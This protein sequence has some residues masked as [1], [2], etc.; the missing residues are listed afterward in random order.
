MTND[1]D[2]GGGGGG[3]GARQGLFVRE[4]AS[5]HESE[6]ERERVLSYEFRQRLPHGRATSV[7][8]W[9]PASSTHFSPLRQS[10]GRRAAGSNFAVA[11][12][13]VVIVGEE[14]QPT[15]KMTLMSIVTKWHG[16]REDGWGAFHTKVFPTCA[17]ACEKY[18]L[19]A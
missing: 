10:Q 3:A 5:R 7:H 14:Q 8:E 18:L 2:D 19:K 4:R 6:P 12:I 1:D 15:N 16:A 13:D 9:P 17:A 11:F